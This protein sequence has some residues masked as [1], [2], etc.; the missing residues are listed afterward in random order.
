MNRFAVIIDA[1]NAEPKSVLTGTKIDADSWLTY[2]RSLRGGAWY[3]HEISVLTNPSKFSVQTALRKTGIDFFLV[4]FSGHGYV[5]S[6]TKLS[7]GVLKDGDLSEVDLTPQCDRSVLVMDSCRLIE[8]KRLTESV[9]FATATMNESDDIQAHRKL[10]NLELGRVQFAKYRIFGCDFG[11]VSN[12]N[13]RGGLF[14]SALIAAGNTASNSVVSIKSAFDIAKIQVQAREPTQVPTMQS[15][16]VVDH[17]PFGVSA[18][19][20]KFNTR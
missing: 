17:L 19:L 8:K 14:T 10:F 20:K 13:A 9:A 11:Q 1:G 7:C 5:S 6:E 16:R 12:E 4:A 2:L 18:G 3:P 15:P